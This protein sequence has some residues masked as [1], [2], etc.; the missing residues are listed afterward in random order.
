MTASVTVLGVGTVTVKIGAGTAADYSGEVLS[1][2]IKHAYSDVGETRTMLDG[3]VRGATQKR[4]Q[5][6]ITLSIEADTTDVG[7]YAIIQDNDLAV[8][9]VE[10]T[11]STAGA[12][13]W[14]GDVYLSLP[15]EIG[16][17]EFGAPLVSEVTW[18]AVSA[19]TYTPAV[20]VP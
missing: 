7:L 6:Q 16:A 8:A 20:S 18:N 4:D 5:D 9:T 11:P 14:V 10:F 13:K 2:S 19:F 3:T 1:G 12:A 15:E 17:D